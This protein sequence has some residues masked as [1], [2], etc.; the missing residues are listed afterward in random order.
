M[1][2]FALIL[3]PL[4]LVLLGIMQVGLILNAYVTVTN[5][6]REGGRAATVY[7]YDRTLTKAL[8][9]TAR[10][11][12]AR[13]ALLSS[14]GML[15]KT[16]PQ[17][18]GTASWTA[19]GSTFTAGDVVITY[20]LPTG[21]TEN[22]PRKGQY[23]RIQMTYHLD[24]IVPFVSTMLPHDANNRMTLTSDISMIVN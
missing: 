16:S 3:T 13:S 5:A 18:N 20:S 17:F 9:D 11:N 14:M 12:A 4:L 2:E 1:A 19:S 8:N 21:V 15:S 7:L 22:D 24:L 10:A 23:V 6:A